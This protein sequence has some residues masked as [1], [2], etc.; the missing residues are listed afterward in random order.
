MRKLVVALS[1]STFTLAVVCAWL[2]H[3]LA[4]ERARPMPA[5]HAVQSP[6]R[7]PTNPAS[8]VLPTEAAR[9]PANA[10]PAPPVPARQLTEEE[11][12]EELQRAEARRYIAE[13]DAPGGRE[14]KIAETRAMY[15]RMFPELKEAAGL[16]EE[17]YEHW[18][19]STA[20]QVFD[21]QEKS[22]RCQADPGCDVRSP[23]QVDPARSP[24]SV[25]GPEKAAR[26]QF[27]R[28]SKTE[29]QMVN[30]LRLQLPDEAFLSSETAEKLITS[31]AKERRRLRMEAQARGETFATMGIG[32]TMILYAGRGTVDQ[33]LDS[34]AHHSRL[35]HDH[36]AQFLTSQQLAVFDKLQRDG[37]SALG[38]MLKQQERQGH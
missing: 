22:I 19:D 37:I 6:A 27:Y 38:E 35:M 13:I 29:R 31:L 30:Q 15:R 4:R 25:L 24:D 5:T 12:R 17:E 34:A 7:Q 33:Q 32:Q 10:S 8:P 3:E 21:I 36:L 26:I 20:E 14:R 1:V 23:I 9:Q 18:L 16:T 11:V 2:A 28:E